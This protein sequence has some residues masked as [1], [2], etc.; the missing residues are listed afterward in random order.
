M[1]SLDV[2]M[3]VSVGS[4][5]SNYI[6]L[7]YIK[8][9]VEKCIC[10]SV[11]LQITE[12]LTI[13]VSY[14][15]D[16]RNKWDFSLDLKFCREFDD[17]TSV[18]KL[19]HGRAAA[20]GNARSPTVD[21]RVAGTSNHPMLKSRMTADVVDQDSRRLA[22]ERQP[23]RVVQISYTIIQYT[24]ASVEKYYFTSR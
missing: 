11:T 19:F 16:A 22:E 6:T 21:S 4:A 15:K 12:N 3:Y 24:A 2:Y 7:H 8:F 13:K 17:V 9:R 20:T 23:G 1:C 18:G 5:A 14:G 10:T